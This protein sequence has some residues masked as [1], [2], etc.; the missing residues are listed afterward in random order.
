MKG[1]EKQ[2]KKMYPVYTMCSTRKYVQYK[3]GSATFS[4]Q[5]R[6]CSTSKVDHQVLIQGSYTQKY[7]PMNES[8]LLLI[9][10]VKMVSTLWRAAKTN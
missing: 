6:M 4:V 2:E 3:Q 1:S 8:L 5:V 9:Y 10:Q 7:F